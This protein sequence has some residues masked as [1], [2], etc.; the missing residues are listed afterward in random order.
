LDTIWSDIDYMDGFEDFTIDE[1]NFPLSDM[2]KILEKYRYIPIIDAGIKVE[3]I[4]YEE[5]LR[6]N[7]YVKDALGKDFVGAV[8]PG[9]TTF[10][11]F[12]HPNASQYWQDMLNILYKKVPF[13]GVWLDM[14]ELSNFCNGP[15]S[16][17]TTPPTGFDYTNDL[18]YHPGSVKIEDATIPLNCTHYNGY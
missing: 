6:R 5:G 4:A 9:D 12:F 11:D 1:E 15:C 16:T 14:N 10:V 13:D 2:K 8:W 7:V 18:P 17:P 3:G